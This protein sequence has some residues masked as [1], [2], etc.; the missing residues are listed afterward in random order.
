M[1]RSRPTAQ[2]PPARWCRLCHCAPWHRP[3][4]RHPPEQ[5]PWH[6]AGHRVGTAP[7]RVGVTVATAGP[8]GVSVVFGQEP[9]GRGGAGA[10]AAGARGGAAAPG[11]AAAAGAGAGVGGSG[12]GGGGAPAPELAAPVLPVHA[13]SA[14]GDGQEA[15]AGAAAP[16]SGEHRGGDAGTSPG[17]GKIPRGRGKKT[18]QVPKNPRECWKI[19]GM[20]KKSRLAMPE[21]PRGPPENPWG[22][23]RHLGDVEKMVGVR[24]NVSPVMPKYPG[25]QRKER[26][27]AGNPREWGE[28]PKDPRKPPPKPQKWEESPENA[29]ENA[30]KILENAIQLG[31]C[32]RKCRIC[33]SKF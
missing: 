28:M 13:G 11:A 15:G 20:A 22:Q 24:R 16:G 9:G 21:A 29:P 4:P 31:K 17:R 6:P 25:M 1:P 7:R 23:R 18:S 10:G 19:P 2:I 32:Q 27:N 3:L 8:D 30:P 12:G 33:P 14:A 26:G 5:L